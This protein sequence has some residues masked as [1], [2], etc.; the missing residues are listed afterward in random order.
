VSF[1]QKLSIALVII[2]SLI[3]GFVFL[4]PKTDLTELTAQ[5]AIPS[6]YLAATPHYGPLIRTQE[7]NVTFNGDQAIGT[8]YANDA[9]DITKNQ[10]VILY[11]KQGYTLPLG[12][13]VID[14]F[15][16]E[17]RKRITIQLPQ[18]TNSDLLLND[19]DII[20]LETVASKRLPHSAYLEENSEDGTNKTYIWIA[21]PA[22][23]NQTYTLNKLE[24][25]IG[26][27]VL[28]YFEE[29]GYKIRSSDLVILNPNRDIKENTPYDLEVIEL[30][31]PLH[32]PIKQAWVDFEI[33]RLNKQQT[34]LIERA[35]NCGKDKNPVTG[36]YTPVLG[37][38]STPSSDSC[39]SSFDGTDPFA[40][41]NSLTNKVNQN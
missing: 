6:D 3:L 8:I 12:G 24:I 34:E 11:D 17:G 4:K 18:G 23:N 41:F 25:G 28:D 19:L 5:K 14:I 37:A 20:T 1:I 38:T 29:A 7:I 13:K 10:N 35:E 31:L 16:E 2:S 22:T 26:L 36:D 33:N 40:I 39:G 27:T 9:K 21:K 32:N 30:T 15:E